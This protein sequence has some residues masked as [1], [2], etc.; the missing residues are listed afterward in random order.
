MIPVDCGG[1]DSRRVFKCGVALQAPFQ[2]FLIR[3]ALSDLLELIGETKLGGG[4][5]LSVQRPDEEASIAADTS[6]IDF[7]FRVPDEIL[8]RGRGDFHASV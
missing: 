6:V 7:S 2:A 4:E 1:V 5:N 8:R 3:D